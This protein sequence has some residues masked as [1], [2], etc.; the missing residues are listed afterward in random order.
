[1][2]AIRN[3]AK[4]VVRKQIKA[5]LAAMDPIERLSQSKIITQKVSVCA[6]ISGRKICI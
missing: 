6:Q 3:P 2:A 5:A 4:A 1:M